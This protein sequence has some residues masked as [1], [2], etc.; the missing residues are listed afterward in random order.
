MTH[1]DILPDMNAQNRQCVIHINRIRLENCA[2][3]SPP[4]V[5]LLRRNSLQCANG[6]IGLSRGCKA[7][8]SLKPLQT[9]RIV[10]QY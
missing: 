7:F 3:L 9:Q 6:L 5:M 10:I 2:F 1:L 4:F 8:I